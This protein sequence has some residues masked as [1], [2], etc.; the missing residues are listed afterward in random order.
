LLLL[1]E[2]CWISSYSLGQAYHDACRQV[3]ELASQVEAFNKASL[4]ECE[5][6]R[7]ARRL[8]A[9]SLSKARCGAHF[10]AMSWDGVNVS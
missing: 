4:P 9:D 3:E 10:C 8:A 1:Q 5:A 7:T 2:P 6:L